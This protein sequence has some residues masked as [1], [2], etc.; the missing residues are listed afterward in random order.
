MSKL[1][2]S[3]AIALLAV[4][5]AGAGFFGWQQR[6]ERLV[7]QSDLAD[8]RSQLTKAMDG[9]RDAKEQAAALRKELDEQKAQAE[10]WRAERDSAKS[11]VEAE[12]ARGERLQ[13]ELM[14]AREQLAFKARQPAAQYPVPVMVQSRPMVIRAEPAPRPQKATSQAGPAQAPNPADS[15]NR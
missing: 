7:A 3:A 15:G 14:L 13:A 11:L 9:V 5:A 2:A 6:G 12:K 4:A 10:Q 1:A 8:T